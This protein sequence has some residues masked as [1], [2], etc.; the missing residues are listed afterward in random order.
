[1]FFNCITCNQPF[2]GMCAY[3]HGYEFRFKRKDTISEDGYTIE[4]NCCKTHNLLKEDQYK[5]SLS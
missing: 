4:I 1:M 5:G 2:H 3:L